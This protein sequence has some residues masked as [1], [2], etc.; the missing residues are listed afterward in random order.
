MSH[1]PI[2]YQKSNF[3]AY[4]IPVADHWTHKL[5]VVHFI[6]VTQSFE[7]SMTVEMVKGKPVTFSE[8]LMDPNSEEF[9]KQTQS[10]FPLVRTF[11]VVMV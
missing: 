10:M 4:Y 7:V 8:G 2:L 9:I 11:N 1:S 6:S 3:D 5:L